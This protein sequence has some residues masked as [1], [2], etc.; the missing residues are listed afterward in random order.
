[1]EV[2]LPDAQDRREIF[3]IALRG[4][5]LAE[6]ISLDN[7]SARTESFSG[8]DIQGVCQRAA[9]QAI[10]EAIEASSGN[11]TLEKLEVCV[12]PSHLEQALESVHALSR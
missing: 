12:T 10:R 5:P 9:L 2:P 1:M 3:E 4:K 7:L 8:A 6:G 11:E